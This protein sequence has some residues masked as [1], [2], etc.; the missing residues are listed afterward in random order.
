MGTRPPPGGTTD[1]CEALSLPRPA[2]ACQ[3]ALGP[4]GGRGL[5]LVRRLLGPRHAGPAQAPQGDRQR[6]LVALRFH[7][8]ECSPAVGNQA[9]AK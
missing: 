3:G 7:V 6:V 9:S 2:G 4:P 8:L 5:L 1:P